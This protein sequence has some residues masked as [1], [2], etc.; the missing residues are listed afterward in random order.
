MFVNKRKYDD[1][2]QQFNYFKAI[3]EQKQNENSELIRQIKSLEQ[4]YFTKSQKENEGYA[5][6]VAALQAELSDVYSKY[7]QLQAEL[8]KQPSAD[9]TGSHRDT[10]KNCN[11]VFDDAA[12]DQ[13][14]QAY[15]SKALDLGNYTIIQAKAEI[16]RLQNARQQQIPCSLQSQTFS[17]LNEL[18]AILQSYEL[19]D[20]EAFSKN[21]LQAK[22]T[23]EVKQ[24]KLSERQHNT[25]KWLSINEER[26]AACKKRLDLFVLLQDDD[27]KTIFDSKS[28]IDHL[29]KLR[30]GTERDSETNCTLMAMEQRLMLPILLMAKSR[31]NLAVLI[32]VIV[33][34]LRRKRICSVIRWNNSVVTSKRSKKSFLRK[35][36]CLQTAF[37]FCPLTQNMPRL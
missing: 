20:L 2:L 31:W 15:D 7:H 25:D 24:K 8:Q 28:I 9:G 12:L 10:G 26:A 36:L 4:K 6:R 17:T 19:S 18:S 33:F 34:P 14:I 30:S 23:T 11:I 35:V 3:A 1:L 27:S 21:L 37:L 22:R 32:Q 13:C 5:K 29:A 16:Y